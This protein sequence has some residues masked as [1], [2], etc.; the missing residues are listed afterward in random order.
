MKVGETLV[1][2]TVRIEHDC[3]SDAETSGLRDIDAMTLKMF[4]GGT[5][6]ETDD[7][8][9]TPGKAI[10]GLLVRNNFAAWRPQGSTLVIELS[11]CSFVGRDAGLDQ[12]RTHEIESDFGMIHKFIPQLQRKT[13][14]GAQCN[15]F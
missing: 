6:V 1:K 13:R 11:T 9:R 8:V 5:N 2:A 3:V 14:I 10:G 4:H 15:D 7:T 12:G